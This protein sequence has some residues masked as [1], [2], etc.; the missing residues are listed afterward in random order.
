MTKKNPSSLEV[1]E[2]V[3]LRN[4]PILISGCLLGIRCRYDGRDSG[5]P[6]I[7]SFSSSSNIIPFCP[8]QLGGL[9]TPRP[10]ANIV[11]GDGRNVLSGTALLKDKSPSCGLSTPYCDRSDGSGM[12]VTAALLSSSGVE[13]IELGKDDTFPTPGFSDF[14]RR[15]YG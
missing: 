7:I 3:L 13:L 6:H 10:P 9:T 11:G 4:S 2:S 1:D 5:S 12:G 14:L 15:V 8:E